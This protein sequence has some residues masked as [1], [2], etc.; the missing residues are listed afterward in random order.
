MVKKDIVIPSES[1]I[2]NNYYVNWGGLKFII[3]DNGTF[4]LEM[5]YIQFLK[6]N[7]VLSNLT[8][9]Y[10]WNKTGDIIRLNRLDF[11]DFPDYLFLEIMQ[12]SSKGVIYCFGFRS[13]KL[14][15]PYTTPHIL[16]HESIFLN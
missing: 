1:N 15:P 12:V 2:L 10:S 14:G 11:Q 16:D 4:E 7:I 5:P 8:F 9:G 13:K 6:R 3:N